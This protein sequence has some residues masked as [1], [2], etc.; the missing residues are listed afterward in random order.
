MR[1]HDVSGRDDESRLTSL[2]TAAV[3]LRYA[4]A[5]FDGF[6]F[7][8]CVCATRP[9]RNRAQ[10]QRP[11]SGGTAHCVDERIQANICCD[12]AHKEKSAHKVPGNDNV[13]VLGIDIFAQKELNCLASFKVRS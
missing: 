13:T 7:A 2:R 3:K 11:Q 8:A 4:R 12:R 1:L 9:R 5:R 6:F 10:Y